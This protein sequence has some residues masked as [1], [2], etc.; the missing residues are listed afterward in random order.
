MYAP[1]WVEHALALELEPGRVQMVPMMSAVSGGF[2][3]LPSVGLGIGI[4]FRLRP[5]VAAGGR[6][7][8]SFAFPYVTMLGTLDVFPR[9]AAWVQPSIMAAL[10]L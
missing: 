1:D 7:A 10:S 2:L 8:A 6:L 9:D 3:F 5:E 4:P